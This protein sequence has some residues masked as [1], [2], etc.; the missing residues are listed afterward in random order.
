MGTFLQAIT[1]DDPEK[2]GLLRL[3]GVDIGLIL[4]GEQHYE[5]HAPIYV[6]DK[7]TC[8]QKVVDIYDKKGGALW[9]VVS[10][11]E[12]KDQSG[13]PVVT[14]R[15]ITVVRNPDAGKN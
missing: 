6:G 3:L 2:G 9:F 12:V 10:D 4:H 13:K 11:T 15:G 14:A 5:Y 8:Q 7:L 1:N